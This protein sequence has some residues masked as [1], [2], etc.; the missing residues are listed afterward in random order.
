MEK[1]HQIEEIQRRDAEKI[2]IQ[3]IGGVPS[4]AILKPFEGI[5][6]FVLEH[7]GT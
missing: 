3:K 2:H 4:R 7:F 1:I 5:R 6:K